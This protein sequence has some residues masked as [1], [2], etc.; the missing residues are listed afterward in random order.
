MVTKY[1]GAIM[2]RQPRFSK[3]EHARRGNEVYAR[4]IAPQ[5]ENTQK[6]RIVAIDIESGAWELGDDTLVASQKLRARVSDPQVWFVRVG[7]PAVHRIGRG[8]RA[9]HT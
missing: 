7:Y 3:E 4:D 9:L 6:G 1:H 2:I 8:P 5:V